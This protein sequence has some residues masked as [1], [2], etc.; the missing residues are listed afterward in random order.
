MAPDARD[1]SSRRASGSTDFSDPLIA[2]RIPDVAPDRLHISRRCDLPLPPRA[3]RVGWATR[4]GRSPGSR[5]KRPAP[6]FPLCL[7]HERVSGKNGA[8][9]PLTVAG[10]AVVLALE[11]R[12][13]FPFHQLATE[14]ASRNRH[15]FKSTERHPGVKRNWQEQTVAK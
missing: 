3:P 7:I 12:T 11:G 15:G 10:A 9:L 2:A 4:A 14:A 5:L 8:G 1:A 13:T 6:A